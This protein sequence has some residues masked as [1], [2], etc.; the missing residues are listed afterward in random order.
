[1]VAVVPPVAARV[2]A[3][4]PP[5]AAR[6][7]ADVPPVA[8]RVVADVPPVAARVVA[9]VPPVAARVVADVPLHIPLAVVQPVMDIMCIVPDQQESQCL[10]LH[11]IKMPPPIR[12]RG[13]PKGA[14]MTV[15]GLRKKQ[16]MMT[17]PVPFLKKSPEEKESNTYF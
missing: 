8:A 11:D 1:M 16:K 6:V 10:H 15:V 12:K 14:E 4:V 3:D 7:V 5:V 17:R 2:V 9:D 13:R